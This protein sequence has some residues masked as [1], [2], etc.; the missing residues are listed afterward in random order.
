LI[1]RDAK[2]S[3]VRKILKAPAEQFDVIVAAWEKMQS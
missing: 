1:P 2:R 3:D